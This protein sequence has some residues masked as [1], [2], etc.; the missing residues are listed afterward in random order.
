MTQTLKEKIAEAIWVGALADHE[1]R[2]DMKYT[3]MPKDYVHFEAADAI[4]S[5]IAEIVEPLVWVEHG[6]GYKAVSVIGEY[7]A[8]PTANTRNQK[9][10]VYFLCANRKS[11]TVGYVD[12]ARKAKAA[13]QADYNRRILSSLGL[14]TPEQEKGE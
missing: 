6:D 14:S 11:W 12:G 2:C 4:L 3:D 7:Q 13:A 10:V 5:V 8:H 1:D 9:F